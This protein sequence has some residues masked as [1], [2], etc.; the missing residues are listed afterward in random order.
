M[1]C[2]VLQVQFWHGVGVCVCVVLL[3][4]SD[5]P[6]SMSSLLALAAR[7]DRHCAA[8]ASANSKDTPRRPEETIRARVVDLTCSTGAMEVRKS[9]HH[10]RRNPGT[11][12][13]T[14]T[15]SQVLFKSQE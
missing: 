11:T 6:P 1:P 8:Q 9:C 7:D 12:S 5:L 10:V 3:L 13:P 14:P 15:Q 4:G 2:P